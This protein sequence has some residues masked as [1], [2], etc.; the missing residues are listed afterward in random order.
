M[1]WHYSQA[2]EAAYSVANCLD[3]EPSA[4]SSLTNMHAESSSPDKMTD[5]SNHS[6]SGTTFEHSTAIRGV[7]LLTWFQGGFRAKTSAQPEREQESTGNDPDYGERWRELLV[8]FDPQTSS[9]KTHRCLWEE[10]LPWSSVILPA[11]GMMRG[12]A[13]WERTKPDYFTSESDSGFMPTIL[14][15]QILEKESPMDA[16]QIQV[17]SSGYVQK[18]SKNGEPGSAPW[19]LWMLFHGYLPT[20]KAAEHFM[21]WPTGWTDL[22]ELATGKFQEWLSSHGKPLPEVE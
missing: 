20:P 12:G 18:T 13:C 22:H 5:A 15:T 8:R 17:S 16:G 7:E 3:G 1:S 4:P 21:D 14:K 11:W 9:W 19:P 6:P 2:L 10:V